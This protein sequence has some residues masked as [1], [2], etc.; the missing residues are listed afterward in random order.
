MFQ[1]YRYR[2]IRT[3]VG[4]RPSIRRETQSAIVLL[5]KK[6]NKII[7]LCQILLTLSILVIR[8]FTLRNTTWTS[9]ATV[10]PDGILY[11]G[12]PV[13][14]K[15]WKPGSSTIFMLLILSATH[16]THSTL[17]HMVSF[18]LQLFNIFTNH[19]SI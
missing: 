11:W 3:L 19:V 17:H 5:Q 13:F 8:S 14:I 10:L 6:V 12:W 7:K 4:G 18:F 1:V 15:R 16:L 9:R 2:N